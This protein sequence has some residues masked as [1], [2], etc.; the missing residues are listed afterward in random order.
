MAAGH[1]RQQG[2]NVVGGILETFGVI[3]LVFACI[4]L[5]INRTVVTISEK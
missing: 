5:A 2:T 3:D 4:G 1:F